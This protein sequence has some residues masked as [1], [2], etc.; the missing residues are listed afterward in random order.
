MEEQYHHDDLIDSDAQIRL[1]KVHQAEDTVITCTI[2]ILDIGREPSYRALSYTWGAEL[3]ARKICLNA[4]VFE[5]RENLWHF[6]HQVATGGQPYA[7]QWLWI[8][9]IC[10]NQSHSTEKGRPRRI[11]GKDILECGTGIVLARSRSRR[12]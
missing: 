12:E 6:L 8:D 4:K 1:V 3:P 10:I 11:D 9:Q 7:E 2:K 5:I